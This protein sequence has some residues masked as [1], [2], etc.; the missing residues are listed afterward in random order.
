MALFLLFKTSELSAEVASCTSKRHSWSA[1]RCVGAGGS[2][3]LQLDVLR[4]PKEWSCLKFLSLS[5]RWG[6]TSLVWLLI[7][8]WICPNIAIHVTQVWRGIWGGGRL[9]SPRNQFFCEPSSRLCQV[10]FNV[11]LLVTMPFLF[12]VWDQVALTDLYLTAQ[13]LSWFVS[14]FDMCSCSRCSI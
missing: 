4:E 2:S 13:K 3:Q 1:V 8:Y 14:V 10:F 6:L 9:L 5:C 12:S 7:I 11:V